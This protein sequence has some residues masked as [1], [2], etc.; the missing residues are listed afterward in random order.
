MVPGGVHFAYEAVSLARPFF[1]IYLWH[2]GLGEGH[3]GA[4]RGTDTPSP[5]VSIGWPAPSHAGL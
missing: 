2:P 3:L 4:P 1:P 5:A